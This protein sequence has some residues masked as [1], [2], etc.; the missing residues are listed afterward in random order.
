[1]SPVVRRRM[2]ASGRVQGVFFRDSTRREAQRLGVAGTASNL[3]D[4]RVEVV[5]EGEA[6][7]VDRLEAFVRGGPGHA[8]VDRVDVRDEPPEGLR[9]FTTGEA[10]EPCQRCPKPAAGA[11][12]ACAGG[13]ARGKVLARTRPGSARR[14]GGREAAAARAGGA[15]RRR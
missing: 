5:A 13:A 12:I 6:D 7:A 2:V 11:R 15:G 9:A 8:E 4:G 14:P 10:G 3:G 1:M